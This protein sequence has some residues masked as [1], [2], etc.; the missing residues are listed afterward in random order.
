M[1]HTQACL[2]HITVVCV[3]C[4]AAIGDAW[5]TRAFAHRLRPVVWQLPLLVSVASHSRHPRQAPSHHALIGHL[6]RR[7]RGGTVAIASRWNR[8]TSSR[9]RSLPLHHLIPLPIGWS[10][11]GVGRS[12]GTPIHG[13]GPP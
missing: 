6:H 1:S 8:H 3:W 9:S 13:S 5:E 7:K 2:V 11:S 12:A 4:S 10:R